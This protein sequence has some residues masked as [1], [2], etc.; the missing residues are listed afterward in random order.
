MRR[1]SVVAFI[2]RSHLCVFVELNELF[3][4]GSGNA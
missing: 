2:F 3:D 1:L 4:S